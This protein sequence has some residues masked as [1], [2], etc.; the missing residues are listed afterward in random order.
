MM[1]ANAVP[2][3]SSLMPVA[4][5]FGRCGLLNVS[6][7][8]SSNGRNAA[9]ESGLVI[10]RWIMA[11]TNAVS[12]ERYTMFADRYTCFPNSSIFT[13]KILDEK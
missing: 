10:P 3:M 6:T 2:L 13:L 9:A 4:L 1:K 11:E 12:T 5:R 7:R 8:F